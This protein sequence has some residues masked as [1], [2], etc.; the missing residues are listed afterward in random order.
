MVPIPAEQIRAKQY[1]VFISY[2]RKDEDAAQEL[3]DAPNIHGGHL[4]DKGMGRLSG[5]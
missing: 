1:D 5:I 3:E 2:A 4:K